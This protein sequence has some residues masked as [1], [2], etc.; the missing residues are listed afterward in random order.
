MNKKTTISISMLAKVPGSFNRYQTFQPLK[1]TNLECLKKS[2]QEPGNFQNTFQT[3][4]KTQIIFVMVFFIL[5]MVSVVLSCCCFGSNENILFLS[6][7]STG[8]LLAKWVCYTEG[9]P[10]DPSEPMFYGNEVEIGLR[11]PKK[12]IRPLWRRFFE[13]T[14]FLLW[15]SGNFKIFWFTVIHRQI[16]IFSLSLS[17]FFFL[18]FVFVCI[19]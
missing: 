14:Q 10:T 9:F 1:D 11:F 4:P 19:I 6:S 13:N 7:S 2:P 16:I 17:L 5:L 15:L 18:S 8:R 3:K 12:I